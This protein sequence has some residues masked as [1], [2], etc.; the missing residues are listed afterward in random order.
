M[1]TLVCIHAVAGKG[2]T[3]IRYFEIDDT[4]PYQYYVDQFGAK[5]PQR[6][7][8]MAPKR[9]LDVSNCEIARFMRLTQN[10]LEPVSFTVPRKGDHFQD[11]LYPGEMKRACLGLK[12]S[13]FQT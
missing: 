12:I 2:D 8:C 13:R 7:I 10:G 1:V 11:D 3:N 4:E 6:G 9:S 5:E